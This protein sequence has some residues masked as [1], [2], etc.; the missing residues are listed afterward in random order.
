MSILFNNGYAISG[1]NSP[2]AVGTNNFTFE[3]RVKIDSIPATI[4]IIVAKSTPGEA[5]SKFTMGVTSAGKLYYY[6]RKADDLGSYI[7]ES[8]VSSLLFDN[9]WHTITCVLE[10][11]VQKQYLDGE[12]VGSQTAGAILTLADRKLMIG[13]QGYYPTTIIYPFYGV[14]DYVAAWTKILAT[15]EMGVKPVGDET[16]LQACYLMGEVSGTTINDATTNNY[17]LTL[18]GTYSWIPFTISGVLYE[19][20]SDSSGSPE[21][22]LIINPA[23]GAVVAYGTAA[24]DGSF[25]INIAGSTEYALIMPDKDGSYAPT[26]LNN[27]ITGVGIQ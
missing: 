8:D 7:L 19:K 26:C 10:G 21:H 5:R 13:S 15:S 22:Y 24:A 14:V 20:E 9:K 23:T 12:L 16:N 4:G 1:D 17:D 27:Y 25:N 6:L 3:A 2:G 11:L 18:S